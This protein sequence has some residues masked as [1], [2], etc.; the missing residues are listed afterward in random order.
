VRIAAAC[1]AGTLMLVVASCGLGD[2]GFEELRDDD[3]VAIANTTTTTTTTTTTI[4]VVPS[5]VAGATTTTTSTTTTTPIQT[6]PIELYWV[7]DDSRLQPLIIPLSEPSA[8]LL[9]FRLEQGPPPG[10]ASVG[11]ATRV[12]AGLV[13]DVSI[14]RG[15]ATV[16]LSG[17]VVDGMR[18]TDPPMAI[19][20][21]V[22]S[23]TRFPGIGQVLFTRDGVPFDVPLPP[24]DELSPFGEPVAYEDFEI[25]L[26]ERPSSTATT[27]TTTRPPDTVPPTSEDVPGDTEP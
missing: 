21:I 20:Q 19:A 13:L 1:S 3:V 27:T 24:N 25:L 18:R 11:L 5:S 4:P 10:E 6:Q 15:I 17:E 22:L 8:E 2:S 12:P 16:D 14:A 23:L 26:V 7:V 9:I